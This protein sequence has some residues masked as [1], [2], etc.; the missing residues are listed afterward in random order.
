LIVQALRIEDQMKNPTQSLWT[1]SPRSRPIR[2]WSNRVRFTRLGG[3]R[4]L[5]ALAA[6]AALGATPLVSASDSRESPSTTEE[7]RY[8]RNLSQAFRQVA[9]K[10]APSV[11]SVNTIDRAPTAGVGPMMAPF[12]GAAPSRVGKGS[13]VII[14]TD[15]LIVTNFHVVRHA[16]RIM[17]RLLDQR[18]LDAAV[19][20]VD[21][22]TDLAVLRVEAADLVAAP[23]GDSEAIESGEWVLAL[24]NP[25]GLEQTVTA[26]IISAK[27]RSGMGLATYENFLQTDAAINPGNSGGPLIDLEGRVIGINTAISS[28]DGVNHGIGFAIPSAMVQQITHELIE[29][30]HVLRGWLGVGVMPA[31]NGERVMPGA[32]LSYVGPDTPAWRAGLRTGDLVLQLDD[33]QVDSPS[34]LIQVIGDRLPQSEIVVTAMRGGQSIKTTAVLGERPAPVRRAIASPPTVAAT[35]PP[36]PSTPPNAADAESSKPKVRRRERAEPVD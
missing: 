33:Q 34:D 5:F 11:V 36:N 4:T 16:E 8:A 25:F 7:L 15:G 19:I 26:G 31:V 20:G 6:M 13:G 24:G 2:D 12:G 27:G 3:Y 17:I 32:V 9:K 1:K 22:D 14:S 23:F 10:V 30:G 29:R 35:P 28:P 21:P 18:E